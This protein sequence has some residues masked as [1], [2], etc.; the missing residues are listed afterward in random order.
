MINLAIK[1]REEFILKKNS[2]E[3]E[4]DQR[5]AI[6]L[7]SSSMI[8]SMLNI[9]VI[10]LAKKGRSHLLLRDLEEEKTLKGM[11]KKVDEHKERCIRAEEV[12]FL[13]GQIEKLSDEVEKNKLI[14]KEDDKHRDLLNELYHK[15]IID[16]DE[17]F[18]E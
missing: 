12:E 16:E 1:E 10:I 6:A 8:S 3:I 14:I 13:K 7:N 18:I 11:K 9:I 15:G 2:M 4:T 17:N 5:I